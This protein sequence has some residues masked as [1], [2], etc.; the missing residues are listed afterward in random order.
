MTR[1][2]IEHIEHCRIQRQ[3]QLDAEKDPLE[4]NKWGQFATPQKL[5]KSIT[6]YA[7]SLLGDSRVRFLDP[8][9]GTGSFYSALLQLAPAHLIESASGTELD[10]A[11]AGASRD[12]WAN[13]G[14]QVAV[15][16]FT[17]QPLPEKLFNLILT[18]PPYVRH[19]HIPT[20]AK[21]RLKAQVARTLRLET[22]GLAGLYTYFL[23]LAHEWL[24][25]EGLSVWLIPSEFMDVN[26]G[27]TLRRYLTE[28]VTL[29]HIHRFRPS[30]TQFTDAMVSSAVVVF[31]KSPPGRD[32]RARLSL[33]GPIEKPELEA[34]VPISTLA[35]L[36]KWTRFPEDLIL[37]PV[38]GLT[39]G[40]LFSI[41][42]GIAT[43]AN[44]FFI[45]SEADAGHWEIPRQFLRPILPGPRHLTSDVVDSKAE[46][47]PDVSP[48][49]YLLDCAED[50]DAIR[51]NW[52]R[53][54]QY[55]QSGREKNV[56]ASYLTSRRAPWYSQEKRPPAPFL[57]TYMG[58]SGNGKAP[59]RFIWN[60]SNATAHNVYLLLYPRE[61]LRQVL[62]HH[63]ERE[64]DVFQALQR[65]ASAE[66]VSGGRVYGGGLHKVEPRELSQIQAASVVAGISSYLVIERQ[67]RL[68]A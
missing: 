63:P 27:S 6:R 58:R 60:R 28:C 35:A 19:H 38:G 45:L 1:D 16:D 20:E 5:A 10:P 3:E 2:E 61:S 9:I 22:S 42:R 26:Y 33:G 43:G 59:F 49:L 55:L 12:L 44:D 4:R 14:L 62:R 24:E 66:I 52:P 11:F 29:L 15:G 41:K 67:A 47:M 39:L 57:C 34:T 18:N 54:Y 68:F 36:P 50:E 7:L 65:I 30:D 32:H 53:F 46:G 48:Q 51:N 8:A 23:L 21:N 13:A 17:R 25:E 64:A 37:K 56:H 31:R 40:D